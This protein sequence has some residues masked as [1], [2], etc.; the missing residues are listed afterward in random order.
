MARAGIEARPAWR[1]LPAPLHRRV[2]QALGAPVTRA[3]RAW[4][5][6]GPTPT[7]RLFLAG[8]K[9]AFFKGTNKTSNDVAR[10]A[11]VREERVYR[12]L[13]SLIEPYAPMFYDSFR[14]DDWHVLLL[15]DVGPKS[16]LP[17]TPAKTKQVASALAEFHLATLGKE[18][19]AWL[20]GLQDNLQPHVWSH[21]VVESHDLWEIA[22]LAGEKRAEAHTWL[23]ATIP[24]F[25]RLV[26]EMAQPATPFVLM[27]GDLRSDNLRLERGRLRLFDWPSVSAGLAEFDIVPFAQ[28][29]TVEGGVEPEQVMGWYAEGLPVN[30]KVLDA[31][32][33]WWTAYFADRAWR[34][35]IPGLPR[36]RRFQCQQLGVLLEWAARRF[37][38]PEPMWAL[39]LARVP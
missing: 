14:L 3:A 32:I 5:G 17:W 33:S 38:L 35:A 23:Q 27:H 12:D 2:E 29:V 20:P 6:Y 18:L 4:G 15:E 36:L 34:P 9:R 30:S 16:V 10:D 21:I 37:C 31:A 24:L 1:S 7:F 8:G 25:S 22:A 28:S 39:A 26:E 11:L 19:P 13:A